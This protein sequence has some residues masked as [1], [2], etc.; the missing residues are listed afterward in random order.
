[1]RSLFAVPL[2]LCCLLLGLL[3]LPSSAADK[4]TVAVLYFGYSGENPEMKVLKKGLAQMLI[5]DL[6]GFGTVKLVE[7]DRLQE[8]LDELQMGQSDKFDSATV[9]KIGKLAGA[10]YLVLG[11]YFDLM[12]TLVVD[13]KVVK[14]ETG[15]ILGSRRGTGTPEEFLAIE[16]KLAQDLNQVLAGIASPSPEKTQSPTPEPTGAP[17]SPS[18]SRKARKLPTKIALRYS[19]ALD[20]K[21]RKDVET[22][23]KELTE[24][25]KEQPDF[26][27]ASMDL[28]SL[29]K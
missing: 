14:V 26:V 2:R 23:K 4:P 29:M 28:A 1:M 16:Q 7:R 25:L 27:L 13:A 17:G 12:N 24:V 5:T 20:A 19:R 15:T 8:L 18:P 3:A 22:A 9:A 6:A 21:D 10:H 11:S